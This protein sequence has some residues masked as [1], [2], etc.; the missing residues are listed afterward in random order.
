MDPHEALE[1]DIRRLRPLVDRVVVTFHWGVPYVPEPSDADREKARFAVDCGADAVVGHHPHVL[2]P[3]EIY[4]GRP[5]FYSVGNFAFGSGNSRA[6]GMLLAL[7]FEEART[8]AHLYPTY[9]KNRDPR[10][11]YQP[12]LMRGGA[13]RRILAR[14]AGQSGA[15]GE[16]IGIE[17]DR[18]VMVVERASAD[19]VKLGGAYA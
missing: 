19:R 9:V 5:I 1:A 13:A 17:H 3:V 6:E 11:N 16:A 10:I 12:R 14:L 4:R 2:Q 18:G 8:T 7:R 15:S